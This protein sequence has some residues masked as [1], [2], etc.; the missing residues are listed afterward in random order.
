MSNEELI[1]QI[2]RLE[3][4]EEKEEEKERDKDTDKKSENIHT[5]GSDERHEREYDEDYGMSLGDV[6]PVE[7]DFLQVNVMY[8]ETGE[9]VKTG[10]SSV[11]D[12]VIVE[13]ED[14]VK[15][16]NFDDFQFYLSSVEP[17]TV[18]KSEIAVTQNSQN[19]KGGGSALEDSIFGENP[20]RKESKVADVLTPPTA[21]ATATG[22]GTATGKATAATI[23]IATATNATSAAAAG[24]GAGTASAAS[25]AKSDAVDHD[26]LDEL[27]RYLLK[28]SST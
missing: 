5:E 17:T 21:T 27:E 26:E 16:D 11:S 7:D 9:T 18:V 1:K 2:N 28:L 10:T 24:A 25:V 20:L 8:D 13:G 12:T 19:T 22:T 3:M 15:S 4:D 14:T 6:Y 23:E